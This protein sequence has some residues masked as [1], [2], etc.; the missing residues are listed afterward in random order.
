VAERGGKEGF[1]TNPLGAGV[2]PFE[3][4]HWAPGEEMVFKARTDYWGGP[5]CLD[6]LRFTPMVDG[7]GA[8]DAFKL[9]ETDVGITSDSTVGARI[10]EEQENTLE[11]V[12]NAAFALLVN[13]GIRGAKPP[14]ADVRVR[15]AVQQAIDTEALNERAYDGTGVA[16]SA[17]ISPESRYYQGLDGLPYDQAAAKQLVAAAKADGWDGKIEL[18]CNASGEDQAIAVAGMLGAV[19]MDVK[20]EATLSIPDMLTRVYATADYQLNCWGL[21]MSDD[22]IY[23]TLFQNFYSTSAGNN[24]GYANP[25]MDAALLELRH[26]A[27]ADETKA[28]LKTI[29]DIWNETEPM[30]LLLGYK[31][32]IFWSDEVEGIQFNH[33]LG[34]FFDE[35]YLTK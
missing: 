11:T 3:F 19:G 14:T 5:V 13:N 25:K 16:T 24:M 6:E 31:P 10:A 29:Q 35:T 22:N 8:Y 27:T 9:G 30:V 33:R 20:T 21:S 23:S 12:Q 18:L 2:G 7:D 26:A 15:K 17:L 1:G 28:A 32:I 34:I 4:D